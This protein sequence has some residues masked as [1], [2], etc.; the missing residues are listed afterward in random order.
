MIQKSYFSNDYYQRSK[1][2]LNIGLK[3]APIYRLW[4]NLAQ[5]DGIPIDECYAALP[6]LTKK[7]IRNHFPFGLIPNNL[8][9][10]EGLKRKEI[11]YVETSG[12]T[13]EKVTNI[14]NQ[15]W[16]NA[17]EAA[18]WK[19]NSHTMHLSHALKEAQLASALS[20][21]FLS[22]EDLPIESRILNDRFLFL[23]EK[24][25]ANEWTDFHYNRMVRELAE[26]RPIILEANPSLLARLAW[27]AIDNN[28]EIYNPQVIIFTYEFIS[29]IHLA[30]I[31]KVFSIP[32][33]SSFGCTE[34]GYL[35]MQCE[36]DTYHQNTEFCRIDFE[37][38]KNK[39]GGPEI[40][41]ILVTTF[42]NQWVS[43]IRFDTGDLV[44]LKKDPT[45]KC[46]RKEGFML[47]AIEGR[48]ANATFTTSGR[49]VTTKELD[50]LLSGIEGIRDYHLEQNLKNRFILKLVLNGNK[51]L[52]VKKA[53]EK[54][55]MLYG[56]DINVKIQVCNDIKP[57]ASGKYRRT[58][59]NFSFDLKEYFT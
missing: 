16:W 51:K 31:R 58:Q 14:W 43:L 41:R 26:F 6:K 42:Q 56:K 22:K 50:D 10:V 53:D 32:L 59:A 40:G 28:V 15:S 5:V 38:L 3:T 21:G 17:S 9:P 44:R 2:A 1:E 20:V 46:C 23:N 19:L 12:T 33:I 18:S 29:A 55:H 57:A 54:I 24:I 52:I 13:A 49:M 37:P 30:S 7:E 35:F 34:A 36:H 27:W 48:V 45:C 4:Q 39:H 11:E 8:D 25:S 47:S